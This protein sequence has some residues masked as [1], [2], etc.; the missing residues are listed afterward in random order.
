M[1]YDCSLL[2]SYVLPC[3]YPTV[4]LIALLLCSPLLLSYV[5]LSLL[6][7]YVLILLLSYNLP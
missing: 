5:P 3:C 1:T 4:S 2:L 7:S 6:L